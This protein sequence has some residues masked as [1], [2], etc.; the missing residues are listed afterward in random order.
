MPDQAGKLRHVKELKRDDEIPSELKDIAESVEIDI[1]SR[2][3][4]KQLS[5]WAS[6]LSLRYSLAALK[7]AIPDAL[8]RKMSWKKC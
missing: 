5:E 4:A 1:R 7:E 2:L 6:S 8:S 3:L